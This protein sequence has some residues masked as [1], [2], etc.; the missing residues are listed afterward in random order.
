MINTLT[1][2][3]RFH[4][5]ED[6]LDRNDGYWSEPISQE[7][8]NELREEAEQTDAKDCMLRSCWQCNPCHDRFL[9]FDSDKALRCFECGRFYYR[10]VD[11]SK[12][13]DEFIGERAYQLWERSGRP[14]GQSDRFWYQAEEEYGS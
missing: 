3:H 10:N 9:K 12:Y 11:V 2:N 1:R 5:K 8:L 14:E 4:L 6:Y 7:E 13:R